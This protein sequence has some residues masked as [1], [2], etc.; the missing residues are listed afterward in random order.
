MTKMRQYRC[1]GCSDVFSYLHHPNSQ[2]D[3]APRFCPL[4]GFDTE[5]EVYGDVIQMPSLAKGAARNV[6]GIFKAEQEGAAFR[7]E[8]TGDSS[9]NI[10]NQRDHLRPGD[11]SAVPVVNDVTRAMDAQ[12]HMGFQGGASRGLEAAHMA[13]TF[14]DPRLG[15]VIEP[16]AGA[17]AMRAVKTLHGSRGFS[18]TD[19][20]ALETQM[21]GYRPRVR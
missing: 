11:I 3:P 21:P 15:R 10:T 20:P 14:A 8:L 9:L 2:D 6:D 4:C 17:R 7:A 18:T 19:V 12:P 1:P 16:N 5:A 13:Q